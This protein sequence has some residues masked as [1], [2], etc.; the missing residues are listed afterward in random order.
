MASKETLE[1]RI[2]HEYEYSRRI[3]K[4]YFHMLRKKAGI[5]YDED[6]DAELDGCIDSIKA[7]VDLQIELYLLSEKE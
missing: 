4:H 3:L 6:Y 7:A 2:N 5:P 1:R